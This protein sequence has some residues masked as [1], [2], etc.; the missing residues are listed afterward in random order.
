MVMEVDNVRIRQAM[1]EASH[2]VVAINM[3]FSAYA[4]L[5]IEP[6]T[7]VREG[8][9]VSDVFGETKV[10][11]IPDKLPSEENWITFAYAP[12]AYAIVTGLL[13]Q[14][15]KELS[16]T[17][18]GSSAF[19]VGQGDLIDINHRLEKMPISKKHRFQVRDRCLRK[20]QKIIR[21]NINEVENIAEELLTSNKTP[22]LKLKDGI[23]NEVIVG[24]LIPQAS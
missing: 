22:I 12:I 9:E 1:H 10:L 11:S 4:E 23:I 15:G 13:E 7:Y 21:E 5:F 17:A 18:N 6:Q 16:D 20:A 19:Y 24:N 14:R 3:G 8:M 2:I